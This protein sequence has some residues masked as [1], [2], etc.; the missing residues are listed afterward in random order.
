MCNIEHVLLALDWRDLCQLAC[1]VE[2]VT[3]QELL[4]MMAFDGTP[5]NI[6]EFFCTV[7]REW[8]AESPHF[9]LAFIEYVT[10]IP[11]IPGDRVLVNP[12]YGTPSVI[13]V[14]V[15]NSKVFKLPQ[16]QT[17]VFALTVSRYENAHMLRQHLEY[18][19]LEGRDG[20]HLQ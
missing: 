18:A 10:G 14:S 1:G 4:S 2:I 15:Y 11:G 3:A 6:E 13:Q 19:I 7:F 16:A 9:L 8:E 17:C 12:R 20:F 5:R